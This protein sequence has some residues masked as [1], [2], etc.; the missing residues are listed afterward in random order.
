MGISKEKNIKF[1]SEKSWVSFGQGVISQM[2]SRYAGLHKYSSRFGSRR[3]S[4]QQSLSLILN[5]LNIFS[6][7]EIVPSN[8]FPIH[9]LSFWKPLRLMKFLYFQNNV[10]IVLKSISIDFVHPKQIKLF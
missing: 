6:R 10:V 8:Y 9:L 7:L 2:D 1:P 4:T 3:R 5:T